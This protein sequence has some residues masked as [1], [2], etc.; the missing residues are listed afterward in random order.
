[1]ARSVNCSLRTL[2][3]VW[4]LFLLALTGAARGQVVAFGA[5]NVEGKGVMPSESYPAQLEG[6]LRAKGLNV[7]VTNAGVSGNTSL[8]MLTRLDSAIPPGTKV[9][10]LDASGEFFNNARHGI[11]KQ[12]GQADWAVMASR[13][14]ARGIVVIPES[15]QDLPMSVRQADMH[16]TPEGHRVVAARLL[17]RVM[18]ALRR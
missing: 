13:L 9:V 6:M 14:R 2:S 4:L 18:A 8:D 17:N 10:I 11:S 3:V 12:Q 1:M 16:L 5:S 15:T 7:R